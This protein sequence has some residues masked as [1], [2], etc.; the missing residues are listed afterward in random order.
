MFLN[1]NDNEY[2]YVPL[3]KKCI[4]YG[5]IRTLSQIHVYITVCPISFF[6]FFV[7]YL[8]SPLNC[9]LSIVKL[10]YGCVQRLFLSNVFR[11]QNIQHMHLLSIY[12]NKHYHTDGENKRKSLCWIF[13]HGYKAYGPNECSSDA[14]LFELKSEKGDNRIS[15]Y[16]K[17]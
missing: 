6:I 9:S 14:F 8:H 10:Q 17:I 12:L 4:F 11:N 2:A 16:Q 15:E 5:P 3:Q 7:K 1:V 13:F